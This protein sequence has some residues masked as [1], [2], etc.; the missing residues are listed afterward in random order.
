MVKKRPDAK[1]FNPNSGRY[2]LKSGRIGQELQEKYRMD[3]DTLLDLEFPYLN[4]FITEEELL[5]RFKRLKKFKPKFFRLK[6]RNNLVAIIQDYNKNK[7]Y[8]R[9][10]DYFTQKCRLLCK[11]NK[12]VTALEYY[13]KNKELILKDS[14]VNGKLDI[15]RLENYLYEKKLMCNNFPVT[16]ALSLYIKF[17]P[18]KIF[19][20]SSGWGDRLIAAIAYGASYTGVDPSNCL[21]PEYKKIINT[22]ARDPKKYKVYHKGI[23]DMVVENN[24]YDLCLTSPPFFDLEIYETSDTQ[25]VS[26]F[27]T[28]DSW[29][30][31]FFV[32]LVE[33]NIYALKLGGIFA[34]Y[35]T[36]CKECDAYLKEHK[37][38]KYLG[39]FTFKTPRNRDI[40]I[41]KKIA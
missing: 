35:I 9:I 5:E 1:I 2:V 12:N 13:T 28:P 30:L 37:Q 32:P 25:S 11:F 41:F 40:M 27:K 6:K 29:F 38:I 14:I 21:E 17:R 3:Y 22:L 31:Y 39:N 34:I 33:K 36:Y 16:V 4:L 18:K 15:N 10:T 19:D 7:E 20:S 24:Y 8:V 26:K 23:E